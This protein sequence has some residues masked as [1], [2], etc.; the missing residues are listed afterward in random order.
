MRTIK[1]KYSNK[2]LTSS[3]GGEKAL[4]NTWDQKDGL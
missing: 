1:F 4:K 2:R 3:Q